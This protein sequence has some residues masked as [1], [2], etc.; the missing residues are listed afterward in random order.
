MRNRRTGLYG[1]G[2][3]ICSAIFVVSFILFMTGIMENV[4]RVINSA[5]TGAG[6]VCL[7]N[8][9]RRKKEPEYAKRQDIELKDERNK[10][11]D[12]KAAYFSWTVGLCVLGVMIFIFSPLFLGTVTS[13]LIVCAAFAIYFASFLIAR[14][15]FSKKM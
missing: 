8:Y 12:G 1:L 3:I 14:L 6:L 4:S 11:L 7:V 15:Y 10:M 2:L 5:A 9:I 13:F